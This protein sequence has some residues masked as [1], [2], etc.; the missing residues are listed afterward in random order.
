MNV[1]ATAAT[2]VAFPVVTGIVGGV[3]AVLRSPRPAVVSGVQHF[4][5][6]VVMAAVAGEVLPQLRERGPLWLIVIGFAAGV[7]LLVGMRQ[8]EGEDS[9]DSG[10]PVSFLVV[11]AIDLFIDGLLV[12]TGAAVSTKTAMIIAI[13]LT[14]EVLFLCLSVALRLTGSG[15]SRLTTVALIGLLTL[16]VALGA[17]LGAL[18][19]GDAGPALL[20]LV[21]AFAAAALLWL[22]VEELLVEAHETPDRPWM[23]AMF[24]VGFLA[25]FCLEAL[26]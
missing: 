6:G 11:V 4:A 9:S 24:F 8:F 3:V 5:A 7:A 16:S 2:L 13:A 25:L 22:V 12:G 19:L 1:V 21:L 14:V 15:V 17:I 20:G 18:L 26:G 10:L 23:A